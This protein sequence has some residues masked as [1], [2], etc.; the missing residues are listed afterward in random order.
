MLLMCILLSAC[1]H[2]LK[3]EKPVT[4]I[5]NHLAAYYVYMCM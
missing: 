1:V 4:I 2:L 3:T 5:L